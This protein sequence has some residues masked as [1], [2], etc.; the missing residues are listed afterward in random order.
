MCLPSAH[1]GEHSHSPPLTLSRQIIALFKNYFD[2]FDE[3]SLRNNFV[4]IYELL[5]GVFP[6]PRLLSTRR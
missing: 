5:D 1:A 3:D 2:A 4:L 6:Q